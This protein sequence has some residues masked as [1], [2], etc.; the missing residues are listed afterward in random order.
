MPYANVLDCGRQI[1]A[2]EGVLTFWR[3]LSAYYVR[4]RGGGEGLR[5]LP[6]PASF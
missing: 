2:K 6:R 4:G 5:A 3:G 1:L